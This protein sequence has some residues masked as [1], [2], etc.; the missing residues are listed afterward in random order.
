VHVL[1]AR[2]DC[3]EALQWLAQ[4]VQQS[5]G[6]PLIMKVDEFEGLSDHELI[7]LFRQQSEDEYRALETQGK[8]FEDRCLKGLSGE[9]KLR[10]RSEV[11]KLRRKHADISRTDFF[12]AAAGSRV[13][14]LLGRIEKAAAADEQSAPQVSKLSAQDYRGKTWVTRP[15]PH[16]DRL[17]CIWLIRRFIDESASIR[18]ATSASEGEIGFELKRGGAFGHVGNWCTFEVMMQSFDLTGAA[19]QVIADIV[20]EIDLRDGV[21]WQPEIAGVD[22]IL[23]G[24]LLADMTDVELERQGV[25]L[26]EGLYQAASARARANKSRKTK[27]HA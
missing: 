6:E 8:E 18:Y 15:R 19:L 25:A 9:D 20:H 4:E 22:A 11:Q 24:W 23:K 17:A 26:F 16:V 13:G 3:L 10:I 12:D 1:P 2:D 7:E 21:R 5:N 27:E 14:A